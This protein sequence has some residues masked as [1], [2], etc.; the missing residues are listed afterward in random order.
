MSL[1]KLLITKNVIIIV[2]KQKNEQNKKKC[3]NSLLNK[4]CKSRE[5]PIEKEENWYIIRTDKQ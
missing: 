5:K 1:K 4:I 2:I 3:P